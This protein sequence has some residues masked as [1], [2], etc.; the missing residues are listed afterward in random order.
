[1]V[2]SAPLTLFLRSDKD[3]D[4][5]ADNHL[6]HDINVV[7]YGATS[8]WE[9]ATSRLAHLRKAMKQ[10]RN[11]AT[12]VDEDDQVPGLDDDAELGEVAAGRA[13]TEVEVGTRSEVEAE[14]APSDYVYGQWRKDHLPKSTNTVF[15]GSK[16][17]DLELTKKQ[18]RQISAAF[19][20]AGLG[21]NWI[22]VQDKSHLRG[23]IQAYVEVRCFVYLS[24]IIVFYSKVM[25]RTLLAA[26]GPWRANA[27][28]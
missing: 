11:E 19:K 5:P 22:G 23:L 21:A 25:I 8:K 28:I 9:T 27:G 15:K 2:F 17:Y 10:S 12:I 7:Q 13:A 14:N 18:N 6:F 20:S 24:N 16:Q 26:L 4:W 3:A 1:L